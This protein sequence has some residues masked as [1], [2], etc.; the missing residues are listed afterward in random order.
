MSIYEELGI[1]P[2][3]NAWGTVTALGGSLMAPEVLD[4]MREAS[5]SFVPISNLHEK[6]GAKI[7]EL[8]GVDACC[9][10]CGAAAGLAISTAACMTGQ[11]KSFAYQLPDTSGMKDEVLILKC[12]RDLYD[13]AVLLSGAHFVEVGV[14]SY[15]FIQQ[16]EDKICDRTAAFFY[17]MEAAGMRGSIPLRDVCQLMNS[18]GIPVIVDAAAEIPPVENIRK[19]L[20]EGAS[21]VVFSG[22]KEIRGPQSSGLI[23]GSKEL[24]V[25]CDLNCCPNYG[26]GRAMKIDKETIAGIVKA[27]ELFAGKNYEKIMCHWENMSRALYE[28]LKLNPNIIVSLGYP[29]EPGVQPAQIL[30][31]FVTPKNMSACELHEHLLSRKPAVYSFLH[32]NEIMLNPQCLEDDQ[33]SIVIQSILEVVGSE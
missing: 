6:A 33:I 25:A 31:V 3:I 17:S 1:S 28:G 32:G 20:A 21:L 10:T 7:A 5:K 30:R 12:H 11:R 27:V 13:Q 14:T 18:H 8:L 24:I 4:A 29:T 26:I 22:G 15:A 2:I 16:I 19:F 23:L 9:V